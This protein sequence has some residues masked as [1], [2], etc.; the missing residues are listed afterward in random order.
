MFQWALDFEFFEQTTSA[1]KY[2]HE[3]QYL[4]YKKLNISKNKN[5]LRDL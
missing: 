3:S 2:R 5:K 1:K 4:E